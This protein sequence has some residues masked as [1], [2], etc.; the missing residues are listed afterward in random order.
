M[1]NPAKYDKLSSEDKKAVDSL[2]GE[3]AARTFGRGWDKVDRRAL[4]LM[5]ANNVVITKADAKFVNDV[6][7]RTSGLEA[8]WVADAKAKG[9]KDPA[10]VLAEFRA[11]IAKQEK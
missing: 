11:E 3:F 1:M 8:K 10:K 2:S 9:L 7:T 5:Q 6:K 4:A